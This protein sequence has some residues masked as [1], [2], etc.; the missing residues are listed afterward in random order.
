MRVY[1]IA[2]LTINDRAEYANYEAGFMDIFSKYQG[3]LLSVDES[4][5][6]LEGDWPHTRTVL[7]EFPSAEA[8]DDWYR[9]D[10]YQALAQHR[11]NAS[12]GAIVR[13]QGLPG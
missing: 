1:A 6:V 3:R 2:L 12:S 8:L 10:E 9:S 4:P 5:E 13:I 7:I 11:F